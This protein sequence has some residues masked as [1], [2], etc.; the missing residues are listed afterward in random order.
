MSHVTIPQIFPLLACEHKN[1]FFVIS[2]TAKPSMIRDV[3]LLLRD[4][5]L[6]RKS[7]FNLRNLEMK[8][9]EILKFQ[10]FYIR[11]TYKHAQG[12]FGLL[13]YTI[14]IQLWG[15]IVKK[16]ICVVYSH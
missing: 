9:S 4:V 11:I 5:E 2:I 13:Q 8:N 1:Q 15:A 10:T 12:Y 16:T 7:H 6:P 3:V 14:P